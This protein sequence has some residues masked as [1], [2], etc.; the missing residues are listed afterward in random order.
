MNV[1]GLALNGFDIPVVSNI[2]FTAEPTYSYDNNTF[3]ITLIID[4][5]SYAMNLLTYSIMVINSGYP[6]LL[7]LQCPCTSR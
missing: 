6:R 7:D 1:I 4:G 5:S 3:I 2:N